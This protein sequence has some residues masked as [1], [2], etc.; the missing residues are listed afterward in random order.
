[1]RSRRTTRLLQAGS[2][3]ASTLPAMQPTRSISRRST[4]HD[5]M[6]TAPGRVA[7]PGLISRRTSQLDFGAGAASTAGTA[8]ASPVGYGA[9]LSRRS[10]TEQGVG[11]LNRSRR[12]TGE[13]GVL[14]GGLGLDPSGVSLDS[15]SSK[16]PVSVLPV[17]CFA[18]RFLFTVPKLVL[19][20]VP[21]LVGSKCRQ[22]DG[23][24]KVGVSMAVCVWSTCVP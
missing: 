23:H 13:E 9:S 3:A 8:R 17:V 19:F 22:V 24:L 12:A 4:A 14:G 1:V 20:T 21:N 10:T 18:S 5:F 15:L 2:D 11:M 6:A 7:S 16:L